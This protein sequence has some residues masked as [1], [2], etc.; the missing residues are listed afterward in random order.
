MCESEME[1]PTAGLARHLNESSSN[2]R[3][4]VICAGADKL[5]ETPSVPRGQGEVTLS[6]ISCIKILTIIILGIAVPNAGAQ[7]SSL[8]SSIIASPGDW[9]PDVVEIAD[10]W[11]IISADQVPGS[12][13]SVSQQNFDVTHWYPARHMP[14]TVLQVLQDDGVYKDLYY[15]MNLIVPGELWK[16]DW[17][18]RTTFVVPEGHEAY[19]LI[20]KGIDYRADIW[21]NGN[22]IAEKSQVVGMYNSFEFD[23]SKLVHKDGPNFLAVKVTPEQAIPGEGTV[24]LGDTW[25]DWLNWKYIGFHDRRKNL[26]FSFP[27]DRNAGLWK[28]VYLSSTGAISIRNPYVTT[29]LPLPAIAPASLSVFCDLSN[30]SDKPVTGTLVGEISR[31]GKKTIQ[32]KQTISLFRNETKEISL[33]PENHPELLVRDPDLW[34]PYRWGAANLYHLTLR[35]EMNGE[36]SDEQNINF[37]IRR[38]TQL[39]DSDASF[40]DIGTGGNFYLQV[41]GKDY[42]IRGAVYTPDL[43][44]KNDPQ[45]D[46][47]VML[48]TQ[49]LGLNMLRWELK[50]ADDTM[51]ERADREGVPVMLG[52]MC[53]GQWEQWSSWTAEDQWVARS[54][55]RAR[56]RELRSHP[57]VV[58][59][60]N[61]SDGLPP[62]PVLND[63]HSIE[64]ELHWQNALVDTVSHVNRTW[65]GI[66][67]AGP[68]VWHPPYYWFSDKYGPARGSSAEEGDNEVIPPLESLK[69]FIP[70]DKL[71]PIN[72]YWYFHSGAIDDN[73]TL[74]D[75][76]RV[77]E[78]RY[79]HSNDVEDFTKK[80]QL[81]SYEDVRAKYE[82]YATHWSNRK[83]TMN[84]MLNNHWPSFFGHLF[85]YYFKQGGGYFGAKKALQP[86]SVVWDYYA[87]GKRDTAYVYAVNQQSNSLENVK[88]SVRF[89]NLDGTKKYLSESK[90]LSVRP[91]SSAVALTV[92][93]IPG[94][95]AVY[96]VRCQMTDSS[97]SVLAETVY[98]QSQTDDDI[99]PVTND[100]QFATKLAQWGD[101]SALKGMLSA[102]LLVSS[103]C[104]EVS[105]QTRVKITL[106]NDSN[107]LAFFVRTE[108]IKGPDSE[109]ILPIRYD[110]N[111]ITIFPHETRVQNAILD[112]SQLTGINPA[113]RLE[114][115][116][117][118]KQLTPLAEQSKKKSAGASSR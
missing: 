72:E 49:D 98:W 108:I 52:W 19:S 110:D 65:N 70:A 86:V 103:S 27:P 45:R 74:A 42:L 60:A 32:F 73:N 46:A 94:L 29:D 85:D 109:E 87:T 58:L 83:M 5:R 2:P 84:W 96:F 68:Y 8:T 20:F 12:D 16:K 11:R 69:K 22:K 63:Y 90:I 61:G 114:G 76:R 92:P 51:L 112:P 64:K 88:V 71:W 66:H 79:G 111:Y 116:N 56:L 4:G 21:V 26:N 97:G 93:R 31:P 40:P 34:W 75:V 15:G 78:K 53:C 17:W 36:V 33:S 38:I 104:E 30:H 7:P 6:A 41:N 67:M 106:F 54:S 43:L 18:Y 102:R 10:G 100:D 81:A 23:I 115:Y 9:S 117:V 3:M 47:A 80:A 105:G 24:E 57:A 35:F 82:A 1:H 62:G 25:H 39:R 28:R 77:L 91:N 101:M 50:I 118:K 48:Y 44:F 95:T 13:E 107:Q 14:A 113:L 37:G 99:G 59:W 55:L 89:Y